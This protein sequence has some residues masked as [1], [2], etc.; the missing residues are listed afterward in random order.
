MGPSV[1]TTLD[2]KGNLKFLSVYI[3]ESGWLAYGHFSGHGILGGY[4]DEIARY[5]VCWENTTVRKPALL[6]FKSSQIW[7]RTSVAFPKWFNIQ[8]RRD[9]GSDLC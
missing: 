6:A 5:Q 2:F 9:C 4:S 7:T 1:V 8:G 3:C